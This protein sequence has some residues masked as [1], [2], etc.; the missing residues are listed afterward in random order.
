MRSQIVQFRAAIGKV[1]KATG[2]PQ[3]SAIAS[4]L[5]KNVL[6]LTFDEVQEKGMGVWRQWLA[7]DDIRAVRCFCG[8]PAGT[9][10]Y[11]VQSVLDYK[12]IGVQE[13]EKAA[14][15]ALGQVNKMSAEEESRVRQG[16]GDAITLWMCAS[17]REEVPFRAWMS[18]WKL[19]EPMAASLIGEEGRLKDLDEIFICTAARRTGTLLYKRLVVEDIKDV[20]ELGPVLLSQ[21]KEVRILALKL[22]TIVKAK[23]ANEVLGRQ[24]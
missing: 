15:I 8:T 22:V 9:E 19:S 23:R 10:T 24:I 21:D 16:L 17:D 12:E 20:K 1:V 4:Y 5:R 3:P 13:W 7:D 2:F 6:G 11:W 14:D 18:L